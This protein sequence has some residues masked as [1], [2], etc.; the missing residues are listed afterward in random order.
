MNVVG[1]KIVEEK[2]IK[3]DW[4]KVAPNLKIGDEAARITHF[5]ENEHKKTAI[6]PEEAF[7]IFWEDL[8]NADYIVGQNI[9]RFDIYLI[10][11]YAEYMGVD[12]K[13]ITA[14]IIDTKA[15]A[16]GIKMGVPYTAQQGDFIEYLYRYANQFK[17]G[18]KTSLGT[19]AKEYGI[20]VDENKQHGAAYDLFLTKSVWDK[21]KFQIEI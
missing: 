14:K 21:Q 13:W 17:K 2:D 8:K 16:Q 12:W 11:G 1:D 18:I 19:L 15:I 6:Q 3:I 20:E 7:H 9:L 4:S 5:N 10:K